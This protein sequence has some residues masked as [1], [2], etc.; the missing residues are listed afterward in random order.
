MINQSFL[1]ASMIAC[2]QKVEGSPIVLYV[3]VAE[4]KK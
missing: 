3:F 1:V 2:F 4:P